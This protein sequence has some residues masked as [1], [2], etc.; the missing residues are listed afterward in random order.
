MDHHLLAG[1]VRKHILISSPVNQYLP[2]A[3]DIKSLALIICSY[4]LLLHVT[5]LCGNVFQLAML[6]PQCCCLSYILWYDNAVILSTQGGE[7]TTGCCDAKKR[8]IS[9]ETQ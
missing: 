7:A 5:H 9:R 2:A 6:Y 4:L 3:L 1:E 8:F